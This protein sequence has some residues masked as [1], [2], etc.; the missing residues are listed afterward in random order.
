MNSGGGSFKSQFKRADR[1]GAA[2]ALILGEEE[3]KSDLIGLKPL[4]EE[5][6]QQQIA[7]ADLNTAIDEFLQSS[8]NPS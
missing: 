7:L 5:G 6:D 3:V 2:L 8:T 1:S 4:R